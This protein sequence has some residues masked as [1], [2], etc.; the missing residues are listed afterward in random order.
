MRCALLVAALALSASADA[1]RA[2]EAAPPPQTV[3]GV[4]LP[5]PP[6]PPIGLPLP[7]VGLDTPKATTRP[8]DERADAD[9]PSR[10]RRRQPSAPPILVY[11]P[12][13]VGSGT[14]KVPGEQVAP[15]AAAATRQGRTGTLTLDT[16]EDDTPFSVFVDGTYV[17]SS[18]QLGTSLTL[19]AGVHRIEVQ[20]DGHPAQRFSVRIGAGKA[21]THETDLRGG[22]AD[23]AI[24]AAAPVQADEGSR[25]E[26]P[27]R[28]YIIAGCYA[29]NVPP[30]PSTLPA[31]CDP[32]RVTTLTR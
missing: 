16:K 25:S 31:G 8:A 30:V 4:M 26:V 27:A 6:L 22:Q 11:A 28:L 2:Q 9:R 21:T 20:A 1:V 24:T 23:D 32:S 29:G 3:N 18:E 17:G 15:T 12:V 13:I 10:S 5:V 7:H 14:T 19:D